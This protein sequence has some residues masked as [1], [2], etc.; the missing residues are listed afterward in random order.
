M[1]DGVDSRTLK[2]HTFVF[3]SPIFPSFSLSLSFFILL[4]FPFLID[5]RRNIPLMRHHNTI[6]F[7]SDSAVILSLPLFA[8][9]TA[10][11]CLLCL[12]SASP[13]RPA[14]P[15]AGPALD[16]RPGDFFLHERYSK[17]ILSTGNCSYREYC[18]YFL[19]PTISFTLSL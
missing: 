12:L 9:S 19:F 16:L 14:L 11:A 10:K 18:Y 5:S 4:F 6:P 2:P 3:L 8:T 1:C 7:P 13:G 17:R 15:C